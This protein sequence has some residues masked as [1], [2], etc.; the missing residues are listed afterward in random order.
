[1]NLTATKRK[2]FVASLGYMRL[3]PKQERRRNEVGRVKRTSVHTE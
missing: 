3:C 1:M 2:E